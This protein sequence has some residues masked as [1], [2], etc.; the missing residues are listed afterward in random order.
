MFFSFWGKVKT[1][2]ANAWVWWGLAVMLAVV[3]WGVQWQHNRISEV[4]RQLSFWE[5]TTSQLHGQ[6]QSM[7]E[8]AM[9]LL[10][11]L[12]NDTVFNFQN[13]LEHA[14]YPVS[15]FRNGQLLFWS[16]SRIQP[17]YAS[18]SG[19]YSYKLLNAQDAQCTVARHFF[20]SGVRHD[21]V[22]LFTLLPLYTK[23]PVEN[24][25]LKPT[26]DF[27]PFHGLD[28]LATASMRRHE[29]YFTPKGQF[30]FSV[31]LSAD[32]PPASDAR[33]QMM[34]VYLWF[35]AIFLATVGCWI[36]AKKWARGVRIEIGLGLLVGYLVSLRWLM[37]E[38]NFPM[39][40]ADMDLFNPR[41][42]AS[43]RLTP[44]LGDLLLNLLSACIVVIYLL[45]YALVSQAY[46]TLCA[47]RWQARWAVAALLVSASYWVLYLAFETLRTLYF[48]AQ[49]SLDITAGGIAFPFL[50]IMSL[51]VF[52]LLS[53]AF[54]FLN[55]LLAHTFLRITRLKPL[56][57]WVTMVAGMLLYLFSTFL[58]GVKFAWLL[59]P[60]NAVY[61]V[62]MY[63]IRFP[64]Y[65]T[66]PVYQ[67]YLY[68]F[69]A[70]VMV[71][72][73]GGYSLFD[74]KEQENLQ[75]RRKMAEQLV[76]S[77]DA[78]AEYLLQDLML[79]VQADAFIQTRMASFGNKSLITRKIKRA[80]M[81]NYFDKYD[82][83][84]R[85]FSA[86]G[87]NYNPN[88]NFQTLAQWQKEYEQESFSTE[89][90]NIYF[91]RHPDANTLTEYTCLIPIH[92]TLPDAPVLGHIVLD[93]RQRK[94][95]A[96]NVYPELL[97]DQ[98]I[99]PVFQPRGY[100]YAVYDG[101]KM[102]LA[103]GEFD[104]QK[105]WNTA[106]F[107]DS[108][109][110]ADGLKVAHWQ[111]LAMHGDGNTTVVVSAPSYPFKNLFSNFSFLFLILIF[112]TIILIIFYLSYQRMVRG[113]PLT[114]AAT[115]QLYLNGAFFV[116]MAAVSF[117][118][119]SII[120]SG[121][122][123]DL[124]R[125]LM[126]RTDAVANNLAP[127]LEKYAMQQI[128]YEEFDQT[129]RQMATYTGLD[130]NLFDAKGRLILSSQPAIYEKELLS[131]RINPWAIVEIDERK[132]NA[133]LQK[134][135]VGL[136]KYSSVYEG[137]RATQT[138]ELLGFVSIP[139][140][141]SSNEL[142]KQV[143]SVLDTIINIFTIIFMLFLL[144]SYYASHRLL[145]PLKIITQ[146]LHRTSLLGE[147]EP[148]YWPRHDE[149]GLL[150]SEYNKM[151]RNL[152]ESKI[153]LSRSEKES[154]WREMAQ[155]VA[156]EIKNPLTPMKLTLQYLQNAMQNGHPNV[157]AITQ[158]AANTLLVQVENLNDIATSFS[159]FAKMPTP[160]ME[161][162]DVAQ[163]LRQT[164]A[165]YQSN[166]NTDIRVD[167][168]TDSVYVLADEK[169][170]S[171]IFTNLIINAI[172]AVPQ[173]R[174]PQIAVRLHTENNEVQ[175]SVA[176]NGSGIPSE[177]QHKV[178]IPNFST[179]YAGSGIGLAVAKRGIEHAGGKIWFETVEE[180]GTTFFI[181]LK[182]S[183]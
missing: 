84:I 113:K 36:E 142:N 55:H 103:F 33:A 160:R 82:L 77:A 177:I 1:I 39:D 118:T 79:R 58:V 120:S 183:E 182:I 27:S 51:V 181:N 169:L 143:A 18:L 20:V 144:L 155:Q 64:K 132:H 19:H 130:I 32:F 167:I 31:P 96:S 134:E 89:H 30:L 114:L 9:L 15:V 153:A 63:W 154:A 48:D 117:F 67:T 121:Y 110:Y 93:F 100:S 146:R 161:R 111:H 108:A 95:Y 135:A 90:E 179:K 87:R 42:Y 65:L 137:V 11:H 141:D 94:G 109:L 17:D 123:H 40:F 22:E 168:P 104:Y 119:L 147:N 78:L 126:N 164:V 92:S 158:K 8:Q 91:L 2:F 56:A 62:L 72:A 105:E 14:H 26:W 136:F 98:K 44:S 131:E 25:Y 69:S 37:L 129:L 10:K 112:G 71:A 70:T 46:Q 125:V 148:L 149:I 170:M 7:D 13:L 57:A 74:F 86:E 166:D 75:N 47:W 80:Y 127:Y 38:L 178:F 115:I 140:F 157:E 29:N 16:A 180:E 122:R 99:T 81:E 60:L 61:W 173:S 4:Q 24:N 41:Y 145:V 159:A 171:R 162:F 172:Q 45:R 66:R 102:Q 3:A 97:L 54:F 68:I 85:I 88:D 6:L 50:K 139:F 107:Q 138:G 150:V 35:G 175:I 53:V 43:S 106:L 156:H 128:S 163:T 49:W 5:H 174:T 116:P 152:A 176:D 133:M 23:F 83:Q 73:I 124:E 165:L 76:G 151:L 12:Q 28:I 21:T 101:Q 52:V 34:Y 59:V